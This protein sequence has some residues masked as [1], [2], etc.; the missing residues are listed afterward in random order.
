MIPEL[1][2]TKFDIK[3]LKNLR[4]RTVWESEEYCVFEDIC[5]DNINFPKNGQ[6]VSV[7]YRG[8]TERD[9]KMYEEH[10]DPKKPFQ[11]K[12]GTG[13]VMKGWD[14]GI[15]KMSKG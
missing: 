8:F 2:N 9:G 13:R 1:R 6:L 10:M 7:L 14:E 15:A 4:W 11:F 3:E 12:L 5:G